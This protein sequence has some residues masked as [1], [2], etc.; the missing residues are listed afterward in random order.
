MPRAPTNQACLL[1]TTTARW[2][3]A[4]ND[5]STAAAS[6]LEL[7]FQLALR[8]GVAFVSTDRAFFKFIFEWRGRRGGG[9]VGGGGSGGLLTGVPFRHETLYSQSNGVFR[10]ASESEG[11]AR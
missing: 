2:R 5:A 8:G 1:P 11:R 4:Q 6:A 9:D 10:G 3:S 7:H